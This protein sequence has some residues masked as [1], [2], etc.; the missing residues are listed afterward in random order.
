VSV[1]VAHDGAVTVTGLPSG[2]RVVSADGP[3]IPAQVRGS[4]QP[5]G[6]LD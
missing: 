4:D 6:A 2:L 5:A 3:V 1:A